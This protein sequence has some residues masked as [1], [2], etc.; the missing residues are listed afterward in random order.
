[1]V[2]TSALD[3]ESC[4]LIFLILT[5]ALFKTKSPLQFS[6]LLL[7]FCFYF[8]TFFNLTLRFQ[9]VASPGMAR[10]RGGLQQNLSPSCYV[11]SL[12]GPAAEFPECTETFWSK[13]LLHIWYNAHLEIYHFLGTFLTNFEF[14]FFTCI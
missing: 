10:P 8:V 7:L 9:M 6:F 1:M 4:D 13:R 3:Q 5:T 2:L 11:S 12:N 14:F